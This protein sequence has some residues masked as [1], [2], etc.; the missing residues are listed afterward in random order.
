MTNAHHSP[1]RRPEDIVFVI[2]PSLWYQC[3]YP[4]GILC[5]SSY[6]ESHG[7]PNTIL[8]SGMNVR[9]L[10]PGLREEAILQRIG[11]L[12]PRIVCF[13][14]THREFDEVVRL[15]H[16]VRSRHPHM[17]TIVGGSQ[18]TYRTSDFLDN[19]FEYVCAGEGE[20]TL[21][22]FVQEVLDGTKRWSA[23]EGLI[24][25][26]EGSVVRNPPRALMTEEELRVD[27]ISAYRKIDGRY[28]D[29][30]VEIIRGLPMVGALLL[31]TRGCPFNCSFCAC[32]SIFGRKL[33][34]RPVESIE[35]ELDFLI[36]EKGVEAVWIIDDTFTINER[37]ALSVANILHRHQLIWG[38][39]SR[40]DSLTSAFVAELK[41]LGCVQMDFGVESG[42]QRILDDIIGKRSKVDQ[43]VQ[44][45]DLAR[46]HGI[47]TLANFIIGFPTETIQDLDATKKLAD[48]IRADVY[49]FSIA[50]P[51]PG[52]RL[53]DL[54]G[55]EIRPQDY[56]HLNWN[57]SL[58]TEQLNKSSIA[59]VV[60]ERRRLKNRYLL[61]SIV[62]SVFSPGIISF[63]VLRP[64]RLRRMRAAAKF[65]WR[66]LAGL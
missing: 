29:Y 9:K 39:Q 55:E 24:W 54:V 56:A 35:K 20:K 45:F 51:L 62:R 33:R 59:D 4:T 63:F 46:Q 3:M 22:Q 40:V 41:R 16:A 38:C 32:N 1:C 66:T 49:V 61:R 65:L 42:S 31:T 19:G 43:V 47:R 13:S 52:T 44:S 18:P 30:G 48:R 28:F 21:L 17:V 27:L 23:I 26:R 10:V 64:H 58:L 34:Y 50:T 53:Y 11:E 6:L 25:K 60:N 8:D 12:A 36:K 15:N 5:L 7:Y 14:C 57:G 2:N 37:H